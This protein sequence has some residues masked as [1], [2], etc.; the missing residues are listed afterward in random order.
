MK[1]LGLKKLIV[2]LVV[3]LI[4]IM[5]AGIYSGSITGAFLAENNLS[6]NGSLSKCKADGSYAGK[7]SGDGM[8]TD[9]NIDLEKYIGQNITIYGEL[10]N[11]VKYKTR[12]YKDIIILKSVYGEERELYFKPLEKRYV[13]SGQVLVIEATVVKDKEKLCF[14]RFCDYKL[15]LLEVKPTL[16]K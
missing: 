15:I 16:R 8:I 4:I 2:F 5:V 1:K 12:K 10:D 6:N 14:P 9:F 11:S 13:E 3:L 7:E